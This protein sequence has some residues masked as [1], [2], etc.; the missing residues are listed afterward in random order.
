MSQAGSTWLTGAPPLPGHQRK[1]ARRVD[2][3]VDR[4]RAVAVADEAQHDH[5]G[6]GC[7]EAGEIETAQWRQIGQQDA[8]AGAGRGD[9]G[10][11]DVAA[12]G[13]VQRQR[14][15]ALGLVEAGP[16]EAGAVS[17][18]RPA[19]KVDAAADRVDADHLGTHLRHRHPAERGRDKG[20]DLDDAQILKQPVHSPILSSAD[21]PGKTTATAI[22]VIEFST[23][24]RAPAPPFPGEMP[25][26]LAA[27]QLS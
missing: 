4:G 7:L 9:Q 21:Q 27:E 12:L 8:G 10:A 11:G 24:R 1:P 5:I 16:V 13:L 17:G 23:R 2:R 25:G 19:A 6:A 15:G 20:R 26:A 3:V 22:E 14:Q 18:H